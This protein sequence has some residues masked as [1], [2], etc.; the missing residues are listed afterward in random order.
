[1]Q[2]QQLNLEA[3]HLTRPSSRDRILLV[4]EIIDRSNIGENR[5]HDEVVKPDQFPTGRVRAVFTQ[6]SSAS[7]KTILGRRWQPG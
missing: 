1:M 5:T 2:P 6:R 7:N 3:L 4:R